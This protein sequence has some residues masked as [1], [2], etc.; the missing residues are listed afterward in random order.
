MV[1]FCSKKY[2]AIQK[3]NKL[4]KKGTATIQVHAKWAV[5]YKYTPSGQYN[6][7][8]YLSRRRP[9]LP[10]RWKDAPGYKLE[11]KLYRDGEVGIVE[12]GTKLLFG[13]ASVAIGRDVGF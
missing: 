1:H 6:T 4:I 9:L 2:Q 3:G 5:Q 12:D 11:Y 8:S 10:F 13:E 7:S